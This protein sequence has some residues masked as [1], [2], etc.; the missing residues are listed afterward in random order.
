VAGALQEFRSKKCRLPWRMFRQ[1]ELR[2]TPF[3]Q[4]QYRKLIGARAEIGEDNPAGDRIKHRL[5]MRAV[6]SSEIRVWLERHGY[7]M[8][9]PDLQAYLKQW[10]KAQEADGFALAKP[11][12]WS[13]FHHLLE[14]TR[15]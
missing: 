12:R 8:A 15:V 6:L 11:S 7:D 3:D 2:L 1:R 5:A 9:S 10:T 14:Y 13:Y 4:R